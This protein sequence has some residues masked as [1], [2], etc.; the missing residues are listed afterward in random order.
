MNYVGSGAFRK[1]VESGAQDWGP[2]GDFNE[3]GLAYNN[4]ENVVFVFA[5]DGTRSRAGL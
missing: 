5:A 1:G 3:P 4:V 2:C